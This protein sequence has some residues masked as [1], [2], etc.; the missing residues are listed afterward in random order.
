M[1]SFVET[2][3][4]PNRSCRRP[5]Y[6]EPILQSED[7]GNVTLLLFKYPVADNTLHR[8]HCLPNVLYLYATITGADVRLLFRER[9]S[10]KQTKP[11]SELRT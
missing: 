7:Y 9:I 11:A 4:R 8:K 1:L 10:S 3:L 6:Q 2:Q 5:T